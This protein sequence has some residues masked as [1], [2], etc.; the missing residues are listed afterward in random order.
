M[1]V[2]PFRF[3]AVQ[4]ESTDTIAEAYIEFSAAVTSA[5]P[6][7]VEIWGEMSTWSP[8]YNCRGKNNVSNRNVTSS[9]VTW[10]NL[11][12]WELGGTY[13]SPNV[14]SIV[15]EIVSMPGW[16]RGNPIGFVIR[17]TGLR[18]VQTFEGE[19][20]S[21]PSILINTAQIG[22]Q[23]CQTFEKPTVPPVAEPFHPP[24]DIQVSPH[25][26]LLWLIMIPVALAV[27]LVA[28]ILYR[29]FVRGP[30]GFRTI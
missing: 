5:V 21:A 8:Y 17:A 28:V 7:S 14:S 24:Q 2:L 25:S 26:P 15:R 9:S 12:T 27:G 23:V 16:K 6:T 20:C 1:H 4:I 3:S 19:R 13:R 29:R 10:T 18:I 22:R 11:S 30:T